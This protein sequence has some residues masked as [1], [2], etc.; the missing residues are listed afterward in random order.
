M[1]L[2]ER[3]NRLGMG[4]I[5]LETDDKTSQ[6]MECMLLNS[7]RSLDLTRYETSRDKKIYNLGVFI[8]IF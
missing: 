3:C 5:V 6:L 8:Y 1:I 4:K 7:R 2:I